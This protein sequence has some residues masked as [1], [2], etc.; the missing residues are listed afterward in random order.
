MDAYQYFYN[1]RGQQVGSAPTGTLEFDHRTGHNHW[2]F[3]DFATYQLLDANQQLAVRSGKEAFCL[4]PTDPIDLL[5]R[6]AEWRPSSTGL[7]T[8]CGGESALA[9]REA[10]PVGW[11]DTYIQSLPGQSFDITDLPNGTYYIEVVANP[12][13]KLFEAST[14]N[15][16]SLRKVILGG[17]PG[18][19][20][21]Q[22]P[23]VG[24]VDAP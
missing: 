10:L 13:N 16:T 11:G 3:T 19:R 14:S 9:I 18:A 21:V 17:T 12:E 23:P 22:T 5:V 8:A 2:H 6:S 1:S 20:T 7:A 4:A 15:N 24:L